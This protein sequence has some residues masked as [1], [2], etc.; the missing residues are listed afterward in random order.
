MYWYIEFK[1]YTS[2]AIVFGFGSILLLLAVCSL[3]NI[4]ASYAQLLPLSSSPAVKITSPESNNQEVPVGELTISGTS[5][6]NSNTDCTVY[7]DWNDL[8][9]YH[10]VVATGPDGNDDYSNWTFTYSDSYHLIT[11]G[12]ND[13]TSKISCFGNPTNLTKYYSINVTG[14]QSEEATP[15]QQQE[16]EIA[17]QQEEDDDTPFSLPFVSTD[18]EQ[19][20]DEDSSQLNS[21]DNDEEDAD[22]NNENIVD[23]SSEE[24]EEDDDDR[25]NGNKQDDNDDEGDD[26]F[27][28]GDDFFDD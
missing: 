16:S 20:E 9:P 25:D 15:Q 3:S 10:K 7:V 1:K 4:V 23:D 18:V 13:L 2:S 5:S 19:E 14:V 22:D 27:F 8:K 24:D 6:D 11:N 28:D 12:T 17:Q 26:D 21:D